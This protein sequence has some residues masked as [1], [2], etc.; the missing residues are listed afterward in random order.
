MQKKVGKAVGAAH[1]M[2]GNEER[3]KGAGRGE[4][5]CLQGI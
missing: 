2:A 5:H 3:G 4:E 1:P